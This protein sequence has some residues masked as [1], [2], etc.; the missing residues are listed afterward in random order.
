MSF[1]AMSIDDLEDLA[2]QVADLRHDLGKYIT[3]EVR[4][5]GL[6]ADTEALRQA[7]K[8]DLLAT[9]KRGGETEA[10]WSVWGRLRPPALAEDPDVLAID[11][12]IAGLEALALD[13]LD[14]AGLLAAA[15]QAAAVQAR[16][17]SLSRRVGSALDERDG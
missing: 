16:C 5:V 17:K 14:R 10:A 3:F 6:D 1:S 13:G 7:V 12:L 11:G 8:A 2:D 15:E 4:F 9:D